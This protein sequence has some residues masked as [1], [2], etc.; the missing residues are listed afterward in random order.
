MKAVSE[1]IDTTIKKVRSISTQLRPSIL[2]HFGLIAAIEWQAGEFQKR[3]AI[4]CKVSVDSK[5]IILEDKLKTAIFRICQEALTNVARHAQASR[6][7]ISIRH[8]GDD[9]ELIVSDNGIGISDERKHNK[10]SFG[11]LGIRER[12]N[13]LGGKVTINGEEKLGTSVKLVVPINIMEK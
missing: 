10:K 1:L 7:D 2:D 13:F 4:R 12:A 3:T 11:L 5:D 6:V 9:M 8:R